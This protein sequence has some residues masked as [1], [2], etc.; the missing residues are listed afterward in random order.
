MMSHPRFLFLLAFSFFSI[1]IFD[2][3]GADHPFDARRYA[4]ELFS[5][6]EMS[7]SRFSDDVDD[8]TIERLLEESWADLDRAADKT[9][10]MSPEA[11]R[12]ALRE[13]VR[14]KNGIS[15][16]FSKKLEEAAAPETKSRR[17][18]RKL[19]SAAGHPAVWGVSILFVAG[20]YFLNRKSKIG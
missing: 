18:F 14:G 10:S 1:G 12:Q 6:D 2:R 5:E 3:A 11:A 8:T 17:T 9:K 16:N 15:D 13:S 20:L 19:K 4:F 7:L